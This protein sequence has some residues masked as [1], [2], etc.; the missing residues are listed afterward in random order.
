M[1]NLYFSNRFAAGGTPEFCTGSGYEYEND[2]IIIRVIDTETHLCKSVSSVANLYFF[3]RF[4][5]GGTPESVAHFNRFA[6]GESLNTVA[7]FIRFFILSTTSWLFFVDQKI[8]Q[9]GKSLY[10]CVYY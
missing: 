5:A 3:N 2:H 10:V 8:A 9:S 1:A 7:P 4:A 6:A